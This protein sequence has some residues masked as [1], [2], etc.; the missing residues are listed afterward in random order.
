MNNQDKT[1]CCKCKD[2]KWPNDID[3]FPCPCP[4]HKSDWEKEFDKMTTEHWHGPAGEFTS[5]SE[6]I[7]S[8]KAFITDLIARAKK[9][10]YE[11]GRKPL[12]RTAYH[13]EYK[14]KWRARKRSQLEDTP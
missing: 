1:K 4:C 10:G 2:K 12:K 3:G 7:E 6:D 8:I 5:P 9:E 13:R 14:R 11:E